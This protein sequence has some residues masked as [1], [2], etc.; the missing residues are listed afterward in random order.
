MSALPSIDHMQTTNMPD[1][2]Y[3]NDLNEPQKQAVQHI[4]G[5]LLVLAGAGTGKTR[6]L[7]TRIAHILHQ[8][9]AHPQEVL[10]VTF[11]NK[12]AHEMKER[13]SRLLGHPVEGLWLGTFHSIGTRILRSHAQLLDMHPNF[14]ILDADDQLRLIKQITQSMGL[15]DKKDNIRKILS[16]INRWKDRAIT[17][18]K[19]SHSEKYKNNDAAMI[20]EQYQD[21]LRILNAM[22]FGDLLLHC[23]TLFQNHSDVLQHYQNKFRFVLVDE[24]QDTNVAQYLWLRLLAQ[25]SKNICCVGDDDQSI[26]GWRGAEVENILRF[27]RDFPGAHVIRL[28]QNYRSTSHIL[29]AASHLISHNTERLG[30]TL[31][32]N[33]TGGEK[34]QVQATWDCQDEARFV[35]E[36]IEH[37]QRQ[38][39]RLHDQAI[40]MRASFQTRNFEERLLR[41]GIPYRVIGGARFYERLEIRDAIA[42]LRLMIQPNDSLAFERII[43][44]PKRGIGTSTL[45]TIH[46]YARDHNISLPKAAFILNEQG[47]F[48]SAVGKK[49]NEFFTQLARWRDLHNNTHHA[50][51]A[52]IILD[53]SGYT[54]M[55]KE[56]KSPEAAGRLENLK[57]LMKA[58]EEFQS[59]NDFLEHVSLVMD[60]TQANHEDMI[61]IMTLHSAKGLEFDYVFLVGWEEGLFPHARSLSETGVLGLEEERRLAYV[62]MT[63]AKKKLYITHAFR[64][65]M[66]QGWQD[67]IPSRFLN[68]LPKEHINHLQANGYE[69]NFKPKVYEQSNQWTNS[70][71]T[72]PITFA[73]KRA[74]GI[75]K[76]SY[77]L[78]DLKTS[79]NPFNMGDK[80]F[81]DKFGY[82]TVVSLDGEKVDVEFECSGLKKIISSFLKKV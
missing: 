16:I 43:N 56:D 54:A 34:V 3:F 10:A 17:P 59:L 9:H 26:Y 61:T 58:L 14:T 51:L 31:W 72:R 22:D 21:R 4:E 50:Q 27:E 68:E 71:D 69:A 74:I 33:Q 24:Y 82:G 76:T 41:L 67:C 77:L 29:S 57:E 55:W 64:R 48:R 15:D 11:T 70:Y 5:P 1:Y 6:V 47:E 28:E 53:E 39:V 23:L 63:R 32:T 13:V 75:N 36:E 12:A 45:Q 18:D 73:S 38:K 52:K 80:A 20:Y 81:H 40:L 19:L 46:V 79:N 30:K 78:D 37:L 49:F 60:A 25:K 2:I 8:K 65:K 66:Y 44:S 62:G 42:Y 7:T 35:G